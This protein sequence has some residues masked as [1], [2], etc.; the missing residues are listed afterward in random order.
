MPVDPGSN[1]L[2]SIMAGGGPGAGPGPSFAPPG[3]GMTPGGPAPAG[4]PPE[5]ARMAMASKIAPQVLAQ[6]G[7]DYLKKMLTQI[8]VLIREAMRQKGLG[9]KTVGRL[10]SVVTGLTAA[11][12]DMDKEQPQDADPVSS[13]LAQ[14]MMSKP[15]M[16]AGGP[17]NRLP[18][19]R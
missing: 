1:S 4:L 10:S 15:P 7:Q 17:M 12:A 19:T 8:R 18:V 6:Q 13:L 9:P 14:G 5:L 16:A 2:T 3:G 11:M